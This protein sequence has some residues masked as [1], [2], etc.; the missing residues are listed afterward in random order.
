MPDDPQLARA[1]ADDE[2]V[3]GLQVP[4]RR[5]PALDHDLAGA[6]VDTSRPSTI[7]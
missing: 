5:E 3:A 1:A 4:L 6:R 7:S 2:R